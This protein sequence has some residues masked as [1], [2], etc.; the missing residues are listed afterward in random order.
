MAKKRERTEKNVCKGRVN[1]RP[2]CTGGGKREKVERSASRKRILEHVP[3]TPPG[4]D[5]AAPSAAAKPT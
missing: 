1:N 5:E 3:K 2:D 4:A